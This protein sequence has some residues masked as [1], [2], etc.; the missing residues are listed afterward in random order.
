MVG[1]RFRKP[2]LRRPQ[3]RGGRGSGVFLPVF[4]GLLL[5]ALLIHGFD[6]SLRPQLVS[7]AQAQ[8]QNRLTHIADQAVVKTLSGQE[9]GYSD[10][11]TLQTAPNGEVTT[12]ATDTL[13]VN[14]LR[15]EI[16]EEIVQQ[17]EA[18]NSH[19]LGVPLG[20][21]TGID[22]LSAL[23]PK[24]PV[25]VLSVASAEGEYRNEFVGAGINQTHH[26]LMLDI[27]VTARLVLPGG[28]V[29]TTVSAPVCLAETVIIGQVPQTY[30]S[31]NQ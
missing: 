10:L 11:V 20:A 17:V 29:E 7:L 21:L 5:A 13:R 27:T 16:L 9:V 26:R 15:S 14:R 23:G 30:L 19:S 6:T 4:L 12:L 3:T 28:V 1:R 8:I 2:W 22:L 31:W 24:L 25:Q 18:L